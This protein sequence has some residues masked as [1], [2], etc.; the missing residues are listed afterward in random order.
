MNAFFPASRWYVGYSLTLYILNPMT[1]SSHLV[2]GVMYVTWPIW[3]HLYMMCIGVDDCPITNINL[4]HDRS[5]LSFD[6]NVTTKSRVE[7]GWNSNWHVSEWWRVMT[8]PYMGFR[9]RLQRCRWVD[10]LTARYFG[11]VTFVG[12]FDDNSGDFECPR[13]LGRDT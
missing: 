6:W 8:S 1:S 3:T 9:V 13:E 10:H 4:L 12:K 7:L 5:A 11:I 2:V